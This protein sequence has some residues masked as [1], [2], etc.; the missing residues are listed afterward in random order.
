MPQISEHCP[1]KIPSRFD[2]R[3]IWFKRPGMA[4]TFIPMEGIVQ[5]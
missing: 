3:K 1:V 2:R 5:E 4:S